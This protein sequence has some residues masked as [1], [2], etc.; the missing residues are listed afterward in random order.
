MELAQGN[1]WNIAFEEGFDRPGIV[2]SRNELNKG[3]LIL[4]VPCTSSQVEKK[5][6]YRNHVLLEAGA[7]GL[8]YPSVAQVHL[9]QP[10]DRQYFL[11]KLGHLRD[12]QLSAVLQA[13]AWAVDLFPLWT[14]GP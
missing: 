3:R 10:V 11:Q 6:R 2:I 14:S 8:I 5:A 7:G 12:E 1:V 13:L 9:I 4:V